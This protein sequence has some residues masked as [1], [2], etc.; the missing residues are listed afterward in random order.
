MNTST[1]A[2]PRAIA[3]DAETQEK[4]L[5]GRAAELP[6]TDE[7][8]TMAIATKN[9]KKI[10]RVSAPTACVVFISGTCRLV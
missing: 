5:A 4:A 8:G 3:E 1:A 6:A 2:I 9:V 10:R 7:V